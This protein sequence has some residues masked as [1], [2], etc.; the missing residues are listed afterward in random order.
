MSAKTVVAWGLV[1]AAAGGSYFVQRT[2]GR[3]AMDMGAGAPASTTYPVTVAPAE[4]GP[5]AGTFTYT[6]TVAAYAEED[7]YPRVTGRIVEM[8]VYPGDRVERGQIV[9]RLDDVELGSKV[10]EAEA[11]AAAAEANL[12]QMDADVVAAHHD[13]VHKEQELAQ[14]QAETGYLVSVG[15]RDERLFARGAISQQEA[16]N[17]RAM[18]AAAR[19]KAQAARENIVH[20]KAMQESAVKKRD[21]MAAMLTQSRAMLRTNE[22]VRD[23]VNIRT[24]S[25]GYVVKRLIAPG[26]LVQPGMAILKIVQIERVR[27]QAN[28]AE[29]DVARLRVGGPVRVRAGGQADRALDLKV[30]AIFP[31]AEGASRTA[32]VE[33]VA[34]NPG[35]RF[36]PGQ[37]AAME[38]EVDGLADAVTVPRTAVVQ[39]GAGASVWVVAGAAVTRRPVSTGPA[40]AERVAILSGLR[41]GEVVVVRGQEGLYEGAKVAVGNP[42][43]APKAEGA[44]EAQGHGAGH[45]AGATVAQAPA[46]AAE[47]GK[48]QVNLS[49]VP[50]IP[51][52]GEARL[53]I[54][55]KDASGAPV[56]GATV[57]LSTGMPGMAGPKVAARAAKEPGLYEA[58]VNLGMAGAYT[59]GVVVTRPQGGTTSAKFNFEVK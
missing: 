58:A 19:A 37:Y 6:G 25:G 32:T 31:F 22:V 43:S 21:A 57:E 51:R 23:Y 56:S 48:L 33:A 9:A 47:A 38:F 11:G 50:A 30:T 55:V 15:A 14:A 52:V 36:L 49:T 2:Y 8:R 20:A 40:N 13:I 35:R 27:F 45:W 46:A 24:A 41:P 29:R 28:V 39:G 17:S 3:P 34:E 4:T 18:A 26:T 5:M 44:G 10:R 42:P 7:V 12:A 54:E 53:R 16:E 1:L 59:V